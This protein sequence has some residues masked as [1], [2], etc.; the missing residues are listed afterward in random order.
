MSIVVRFNPTNVTREKYD[1]SVRRLEQAGLWPNPAGL[2]LAR[3]LRVG[4]K[5]ACQRNLELA[6]ADGGVR[7][8]ADA[9]PRRR[10]NRVLVPSRRSS[11]FTTSSRTDLHDAEDQTRSGQEVA[12]N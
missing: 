6:G 12:T 4:R 8:A 1:E 2:E 5:P 9:H 7:R 11:R 3:S 10:W